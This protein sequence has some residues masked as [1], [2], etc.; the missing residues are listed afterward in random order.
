MLEI[1]I[2]VFTCAVMFA[3]CATVVH[4]VGLTNELESERAMHA[5]TRF[6]L[7]EREVTLTDLMAKLKKYKTKSPQ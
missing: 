5:A 1:L 3:L 7:A 4:G 2:L 6:I